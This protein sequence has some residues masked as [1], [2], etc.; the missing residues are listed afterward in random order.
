M[1]TTIADV[2]SRLGDKDRYVNQVLDRMRK[3]AK[4]HGSSVV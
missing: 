4:E 2:F 1:P 3:L